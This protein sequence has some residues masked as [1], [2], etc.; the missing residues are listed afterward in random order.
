MSLNYYQYAKQEVT[1]G[2]L[3]TG[4]DALTEVGKS[5]YKDGKNGYFGLVCGDEQVTS[6]SQGAMLLMNLNVDFTNSY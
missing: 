2:I 1:L 3:G 6:Y 5:L 4:E